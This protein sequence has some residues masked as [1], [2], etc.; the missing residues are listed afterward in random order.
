MIKNKFFLT[1]LFIAMCLII[2]LVKYAYNGMTGME[3]GLRFDKADKISKAVF[4]DIEVEKMD[5]AALNKIAFSENEKA[6]LASYYIAFNQIKTGDIAQASLSL[7]KIIEKYSDNYLAPKA[8]IMLADIYRKT[9]ETSAEIAILNRIVE[10]Y[11]YLPE[12]IPCYYKLAEIYKNDKKIDRYYMV[13]DS[14]EIRAKKPEDKIPALFMN[15]NERLKNFDNQALNKFETL[16]MLKETTI[17]QK[18]QAF[19]GKAA[20]Y[21]NMSM[22]DKAAVV[23]DEVIKMNG[24][25]A[26]TVD[27]ANLFK[28]RL[29]ADSGKGVIKTAP[30]PAGKSGRIK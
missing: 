5:M 3:G 15:A 8:C 18:A 1:I 25:D 21:E 22:P 30:A 28:Q 27:T 13:L 2:V 17:G 29:L 9:G 4:T 11:S 16:I 12:I 26:K 24:I 23:Y 10:K 19:L 6:P 7:K 14:I 20:V